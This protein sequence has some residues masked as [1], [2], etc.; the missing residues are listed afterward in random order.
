MTNQTRK[1]IRAGLETL[2]HGGASAISSNLGAAAIDSKD[3]GLGSANG[4]KLAAVT[5][6]ANG[7]LRFFQ[8]WQN[9]PLPEEGTAPPIGAPEPSKISISPLSKVQSIPQQPPVTG[10]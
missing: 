7:G 10:P 3:W 8:W 2:I 9:N 6:L 5:F 4:W 1:W